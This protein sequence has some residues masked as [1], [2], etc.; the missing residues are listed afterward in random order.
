MLDVTITGITNYGLFIDYRGIQGLVHSSEVPDKKMLKD[1]YDIFHKEDVIHSVLLGVKDNRM[2][3]TVIPDK[4]ATVTSDQA[5]H[6]TIRQQCE[7]FIGKFKA[8]PKE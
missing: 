1:R 2:V 5:I 8:V 7:G 3:L 6:D 4:V